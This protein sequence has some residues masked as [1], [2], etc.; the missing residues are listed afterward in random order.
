MNEEI[1]AHTTA[2][3]PCKLLLHPWNT[4]VTLTPKPVILS[5]Q[6]LCYCKQK[7]NKNMRNIFTS[8]DYKL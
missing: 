2:G 3:V 7:K 6:I 5:G 1:T 4:S 8:H